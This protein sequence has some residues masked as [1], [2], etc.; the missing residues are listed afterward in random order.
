MFRQGHTWR[1][2]AAVP[3]DEVLELGGTGTACASEGS[4]SLLL[5]TQLPNWWSAD[6]S[7][8]TPCRPRNAEV[9]Q[10]IVRDH[11]PKRNPCPRQ[12]VNP[13]DVEKL[14]AKMHVASFQR[15]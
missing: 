4:Q 13:S 12:T 3:L 15:L 9:V 1:I 7:S 10:I 14:F 5:S 2:N 8:G 11:Q 6:F